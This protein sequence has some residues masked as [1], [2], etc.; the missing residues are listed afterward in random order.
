MEVP[1]GVEKVLVY[2]R[3]NRPVLV[4]EELGEFIVIEKRKQTLDQLIRI[5]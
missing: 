5:V 1:Q 3:M 2:R 4:M